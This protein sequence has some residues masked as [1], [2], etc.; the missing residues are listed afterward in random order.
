M[1]HFAVEI[2]KELTKD[3]WLKLIA[4][5]TEKKYWDIGIKQIIS[6]GQMIEFLIEEL[7]G[8]GLFIDIQKDLETNKLVCTLGS[9]GYPG[10]E[11]DDLCV[12][13]WEK[14]KEHL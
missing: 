14:T 13:L 3:Q 4:W 8:L 5:A 11:G 10:L 1:K 6:D 2:K 12:L 9:E 7:D